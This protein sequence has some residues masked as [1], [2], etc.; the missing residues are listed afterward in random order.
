MKK[1]VALLLA[2]IML[3]CWLP[4]LAEEIDNPYEEYG[5]EILRDADGNVIDLGGMEIIVCE[6][7]KSDWHDQ[8]PETAYQEATYEYRE[9]L[10]ET[11]N[12][13][14][15]NL[16]DTTW[17]S[18][19]DDFNNIATTD[20]PKN[21]VWAMRFETIPGPMAN[22][23]F[24]DLAT[25]DCLDF[26]EAKWNTSAVKSLTTVGDH[27]YGMRAEP[28]EARGGVYF[29]KRLLTEAGIDPDEIYDMQ[30]NGTWTWDAFEE[31]L[32]KCTK[33]TD[34]DGVIDKYAMM[35][36]SPRLLLPAIYSNNANFFGLDENGKFI[37]TAQSDAFMEAAT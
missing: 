24:Y 33:D 37:V 11:Y 32:K 27:I 30:A 4:S 1:L 23:L 15:Y 29:N 8:D 2:A 26:S 5:V 18:C 21:Y 17:S 28:A 10:E 36:F 6:H 14:I 25:L 19:P 20:E 34:N 22:G 35:S 7:W 31:L 12:F 16:A 13:K 3:M 9:W